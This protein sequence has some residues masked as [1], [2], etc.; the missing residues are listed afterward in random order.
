MLWRIFDGVFEQF[1]KDLLHS[2]LIEEVVLL[3]LELLLKF[4]LDLNVFQPGLLLN[5]AD[6]LS[7]YILD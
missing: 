1:A 4:Q 3:F 6:R 5:E 7:H 2:V